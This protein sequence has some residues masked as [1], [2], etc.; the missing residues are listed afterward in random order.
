MPDGIA[1]LNRLRKKVAAN[2]AARNPRPE[3]MAVVTATSPFC[4]YDAENDVY[5]FPITALRA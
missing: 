4:R 5:V 2:P 3:F 1:N